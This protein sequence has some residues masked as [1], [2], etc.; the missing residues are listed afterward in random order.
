MHQ[1]ILAQL[2]SRL[3]DEMSGAFRRIAEMLNDK[4]FREMLSEYEECTKCRRYWAGS[5]RRDRDRVVEYTNL[6]N[7]LEQ[8]ILRFLREH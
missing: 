5:P 6:A 4:T 1:E 8:E 3:E 2:A 7:D